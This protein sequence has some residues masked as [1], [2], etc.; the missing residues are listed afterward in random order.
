MVF[1]DPPYGV[2]IGDKNKTLTQHGFGG[3]IEQNIIGDTLPP[4]ELCKVLVKAFENL[5]K[6]AAADHCS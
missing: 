6:N 2:S 5:R 4:E 3:G 1:T